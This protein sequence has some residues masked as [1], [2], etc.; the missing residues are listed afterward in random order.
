MTEPINLTYKYTEAEYTSAARFFYAR[1]IHTKFNLTISIIA[2]LSGIIGVTLTGDSIVWFLL[3]FVG[4]ILMMLS[5]YA[6]FITPRQHYQRNPKFREQYHLQFSEDGLL[7]RSDNLESR[8]EWGFYSTA[9]ETPQFFFLLYGKDMFTLIPK[10]VFTNKAQETAFR[11]F[12]K[13]KVDLGI[14]L[15]NLTYKD[16]VELNG[17]Y[18]PPQSP[19][20]WR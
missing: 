17:E 15:Y 12:L 1:S 6:H 10:R 4:V 3:M 7:F 5:G 13:R 18:E 9:W 16:T 2:I 20:D 19:P 14:K 8:L 11:D